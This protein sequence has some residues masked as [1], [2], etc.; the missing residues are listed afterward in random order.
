[1]KKEKCPE[2]R[3]NCLVRTIWK[4]PSSWIKP[5]EDLESNTKPE[6][7]IKSFTLGGWKD[8]SM[9]RSTGCLPKGPGFTSQHPYS[10][11][12]WHSSSWEFDSSG[13]LEH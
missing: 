7:A 10:T 6:T 12:N 5:H 4:I 1:M 9:V 13:F 3:F 8:S 11:H 2:T